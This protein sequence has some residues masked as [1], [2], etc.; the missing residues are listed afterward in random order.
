MSI[1]NIIF[2]LGG[3]ILEIDYRRTYDAFHKLG[4][5]N[6]D[7]L[8]SSLAQ[9]VFFD[10]FET[11]KITSELFRATINDRL[12]IKVSDNQFDNAWNAML[13]DLPR[14]RLELIK[15]LQKKY[16]VFLLSNANAIHIDAVF[17]MCHQLY[18]FN[19]FQDYFDKDYY[20]YQIGKRKPHPEAFLHVMHENKIQAN[21]TLFVDDVL[22]N[23]QGAQCVDLH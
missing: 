7:K 8:Y 6:L 20:S 14:D 21:E 2:D 4:A 22:Q 5:S 11:G 15:S 23:I 17:S 9:D 18:G 10:D 12:N 3:V 1:K 16:K 19:V 13:V